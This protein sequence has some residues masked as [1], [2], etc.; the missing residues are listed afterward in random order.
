MKSA[1]KLSILSGL[2]GGLCGV[3]AAGSGAAHSPPLRLLHRYGL[4]AQVQGHFDHFA[5]DPASMR[6]FG[7]AVDSHLLVVFNFATGKIIRLI[8]VATPRGV[9]YRAR[10]KRL[11]VT[12]GSGSL[13]IFDARTYALRKV[14][15]VATDADPIAYNAATG[16]IFVVN[17][18]EKAHHDYSDITVF[19]SVSERQ[20]GNI[21]VPGS[22]IEDFGIESHGARLFANVE[23]LN[24]VDVINT[25]TLKLM[26]VWPLTR[27]K[28][29][30]GA[31]VDLRDHRLFVA[32]RQGGLLVLDSDTGRQLQTL[33]IGGDTD[34]IAFDPRSRRIY[35][36]GGGA[37][38]WVDVY[39]VEDANHYHLLG[40]VTTEPGAATSQLVATLGEYIVM[41]PSG[42]HR[43]AQ[44][45]VYGITS[46]KY[47]S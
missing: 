16:R 11:Y 30:Y 47:G 14:L 31:A 12:D 18:G 10:L 7:T 23:A 21:T 1:V 35:V 33:P 27:A 6:L 44:V 4:P 36:S 9:I 46:A 5:V 32:C 20:V 34:Y 39:Q 43:P 45:W 25:H 24:Q 40:E 42:A 22:D 3:L 37:H 29:N 8:H 15:P 13:R 41:T 38:G 28:V 26:A 17:G 19:D 2:A